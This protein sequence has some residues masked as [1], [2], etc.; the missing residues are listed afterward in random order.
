MDLQKL[1]E[2]FDPKHLEW[3][4]GRCGFRGDEPWATVLA[5]IT[6]RAVMDRL[7]EVCGPGNWQLTEPR[8]IQ[9]T[10][11]EGFVVGLSILVDGAWVTKYD[12][13]NLSDIETFKGGLSGA[14]KRAAVLWGIGRYLYDLGDTWAECTTERRPYRE[15]W[16]KGY[17]SRTKRDFYWR[18]PSN[19]LPGWALPEGTQKPSQRAPASGGTASRPSSPVQPEAKPEPRLPKFLAEGDAT[20][21]RPWEHPDL[22]AY[23]QKISDWKGVMHVCRVYT[24]HNS[25]KKTLAEPLPLRSLRTEVLS[26]YADRW[27]LPD[28]ATEEEKL[29][30][31]ALNIWRRTPNDGDPETS[32]DLAF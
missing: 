20:S 4:V 10:K 3:R 24:D 6:S 21:P 25:G 29:L 8:Y 16:S 5:Y 22:T 26:Y 1:H 15:G 30:R 19:P 11:D 9:T 28:D 18:L 17:D 31:A 23:E 12:G 14:L 7:D 13:A 27:I 2:P 32:D